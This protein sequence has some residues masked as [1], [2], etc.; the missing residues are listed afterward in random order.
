[1]DQLKIIKLCKKG[2]AKGFELLVHTYAPMLLG[3]CKRYMIDEAASK[4]ALQN[5]LIDIFR[6]IKKYKHQG[7]F[8]AWMKKI[9]VNASLKLLRKEKKHSKSLTVIDDKDYLNLG[10]NPSIIDQLNKDA[11]IDKINKLP[12][13]FRLIINLYII[14]G[15]SYSE[16]A[17]LMDLKESHCRVKVSRARKKLQLLL[18]EEKASYG[19]ARSRKVD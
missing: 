19:I 3:I 12:E 7:K 8:E 9:A 4:D 14:E 1:M 11:V 2:D 15:Y 13:D 6:H 10:A 17:E 18:T 5:C 16:I